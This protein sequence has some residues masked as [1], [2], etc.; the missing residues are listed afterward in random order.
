MHLCSINIPQH[1]LAIWRNA[2]ESRIRFDIKP[3][4][5]ILDQNEIWKSH[6]ELVASMR[7]YLPTSFD[8][9]PRNPALKIN[10]GFK[11]CEYLLYFW[12]LGPVVF[13]PL[14]P[15]YLWTHFCKLVSATRIIHQRIITRQQLET[16]HKLIL[17]WEMEFEQ[18]YYARDLS[19][20]HYVRPCI[21]AMIHTAQET[22][23][24]GPL[25]LLAQ[26]AL[27]NTIGNLGRK[28]RQPSNA[29]SNL[30]ERGLLRARQNA[31]MA[32]L[33]DL[34]I[35]SHLPR[36]SLSLGNQYYLLRACERNEK[37]VQLESEASTIRN[38]LNIPS[39]SPVLIQK[40]ARLLLPNQQIARSL[41][42]DGRTQDGRTSRN[43][44][45]N[46]SANGYIVFA[47]VKYFFTSNLYPG[48]GQRAFALVSTY[49]NPDVEL[50]VQSHNALWVSKHLGSHGLR[51]ID[52]KSIESVVAMVPF[53]LKEEEENNQTFIRKYKDCMCM[54]EKPFL[55]D[56]SSST[57]L[58]ELEH[59][60]DTIDN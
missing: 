4:F 15:H 31:L 24:C 8:Q 12:A 34:A 47:E 1:L 14:L 29:F 41:W 26:W 56:V 3:D 54:I 39:S 17:E 25:N 5:I 9:P 10:S 48:P 28:V 57:L 36:G 20:L 49:S 53:A 11:A 16:A 33:P 42:R 46:V 30:A 43:V 59:E 50:L 32:I 40:W 45:L 38:A 60:E 2:G 22:V 23:R 35:N 37:M 27:E 51:V 6:G 18:T 19:R 13:R 44:K 58:E 21:H 55:A 7:P 52:P